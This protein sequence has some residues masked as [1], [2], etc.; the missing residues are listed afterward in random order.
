MH[1]LKC[2]ID[3]MKM[4]AWRPGR[5]PEKPHVAE[6]CPTPAITL[7]EQMEE[8][9][10]EW[11]GALGKPVPQDE[12]QV[13]RQTDALEAAEQT[14]LEA[15][16]KPKPVYGTPEFWKDYWARKKAGLVPEKKVSKREATKK[17]KS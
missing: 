2:N 17:Q 16:Y 10:R 4:I 12:I 13:C 14:R 5:E 3:G 6:P 11:Y 8:A 7:G 15:A 9:L 1:F